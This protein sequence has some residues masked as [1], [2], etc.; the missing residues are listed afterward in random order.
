LSAD[1]VIVSH[2]SDIEKRLKF[3]SDRLKVWDYSRPCSITLKPYSNP[4]SI[5][6]NAMFH[7]WCK[8]LSEWVIKRDPSYTPENVK[9][10]LKQL[11]LG[12][13]D[14]KVGKTIVKDQLRHTATL[15][16]GEM[17]DFLNKV[18][19]WAFDLGF[20]LYY[21]PQSEYSKLKNKQVE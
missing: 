4:R 20:N 10:L 21:D 8:Q 15:D 9:L 14:I 6:Q 12:V 3:L 1:K 7:S 11:F 5:S 19:N 2:E 18:Y 16:V 17:L 13:E